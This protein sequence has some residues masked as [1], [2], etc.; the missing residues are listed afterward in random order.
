M[1]PKNG[2]RGNRE[3]LGHRKFHLDVRKNFFPVRVTGQWNSLSREVVKSPS[4]E[5]SK[6]PPDTVL[7]DALLRTLLEQGGWVR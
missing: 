4:P 3:K 6:S 5:I 7:S 2:K 1:V